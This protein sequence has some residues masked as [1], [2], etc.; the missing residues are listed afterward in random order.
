MRIVQVDVVFGV[1]STGKIVQDLCDGL[2]KLGHE[3]LAAYGRGKKSS[4]LGVLKIASNA[5]VVFHAGM[6]RL[7]GWTGCFS[8]LATRRLKQA[9]NEFQPDVVHLHEMHGYYV[10][11]NDI[12]RFLG[13]RRIPIVW[14]FHSEFMYTGKCG[15][16][17]ECER[18]K[19]GCHDCPQ[20]R[21]CPSS[22]LFDHTKQ[23]YERKRG[24]FQFLSKLRLVT[25]SDWLKQRVGESFLRERQ[26]DIVYNGVDTTNVFYPRDRS[27]ARARLGITSKY[28]V[29]SVAPKLMIPRKGGDWVL[30]LARRMV[31]VD[32]TF[33]MIGVDADFRID[34]PNVTALPRTHDQQ[35]LAEVYSASDVFLLPSQKETFSMVVVESLACGTPVVGFDCGAPREVAPDGYGHWVNY[36]DIDALQRVLVGVLDGSLPMKTREEC[37]MFAENRYSKFSMVEKYLNIYRELD[38][39]MQPHRNL[40]QPA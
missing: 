32:V 36:G 28:V 7:T 17:N 5:E 33:L 23:M 13:D 9:I 30:E 20:L 27:M 4:S 26:V 25:P 2:Q 3:V 34:S 12:L 40:K 11:I 22:L 38:G 39:S 16:A 14:T 6:T 24:T 35:F 37:R 8:P 19:T 10:N 29:V 18:W 15:Y 1:L 21:E 31:E